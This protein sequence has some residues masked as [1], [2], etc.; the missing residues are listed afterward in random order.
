MSRPDAIVIGAGFAGLSAAVRLAQGGAQVLVVEE[1]RRLGGRATAFADPHT[2][3]IVDNGQHALFGCYRE[4]F[5]FLRAIDAY[6]QVS[7]DER[8][9]IEIVDRRASRSRLVTPQWPPPLHLVGGL[10]RW[11]ALGMRDRLAALRMGRVLGRLARRN[12][13]AAWARLG[14]QTAEAWLVECGQTPRLRELLWEPL[15]V[16]ALN[17]SPA[18][19]AAAPFV[20][21][22]ARMFTGT[23]SDAAIG[24]PRVPLD[25]LYAEPARRWLEAR[26]SSVRVGTAATLVVES[27]KAIGVDLGD[28][29]VECGAVVSSVPWFSFP[30]LVQGIPALA[31]I[32]DNAGLMA[33]SPIVTVNLW[34]D[35]SV[36]DTAFVGLPGRTFQWVFDK[37]RIFGGAASHLSLVSSGADAVV[38]MTNDQLVALARDEVAAALPA[39]RSATVVRGTAVREKRATFSLA[40][41][42]PPRPGT[43]TPVRDFYL[44]GD[45]TDTGLPATIEGAVESGHRAAALVSNARSL[46]PVA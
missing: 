2:G 42:Q 15:A 4:T 41:G 44:A 20:R 25:V 12:D 13:A 19:A 38:A 3:E 1:R 8:L 37:G 22:L 11:P 5:A 35:R 31:P 16:A 24:L 32:S 40:P 18:T 17:Q 10:L 9:D 46:K 7:L 45:W 6:A 28:Q 33:A 43:E 26:G 14:D 21:V 23:R 27:G 30:S 29:R 34:Y 36:T 39:A